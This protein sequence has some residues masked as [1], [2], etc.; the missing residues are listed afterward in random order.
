MQTPVLKVNLE[1]NLEEYLFIDFPS[2]FCTNEL[3]QELFSMCKRLYILFS[4]V[5]RSTSW[6]LSLGNIQLANEQDQIS[7]K[8]LNPLKVKK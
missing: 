4:I 8:M 3:I 6:P 2:N 7:T 5:N 1:A